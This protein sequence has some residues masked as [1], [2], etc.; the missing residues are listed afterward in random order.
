[1]F[2]FEKKMQFHKL[3]RLRQ[4]KGGEEKNGIRPQRQTAPCLAVAAPPHRQSCGDQHVGCFSYRRRPASFL[5][6]PDAG[7]TVPKR[8]NRETSNG[9]RAKPFP[10]RQAN[11]QMKM[12]KKKKRHKNGRD[13]RFF[14][15]WLEEGEQAQRRVS[16]GRQSC[17]RSTP[18]RDR[19]RQRHRRH[20]RSGAWTARHGP[21]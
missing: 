17:W 18:W 20:R 9:A 11:V 8:K 2:F 21:H 13:L 7:S 4:P 16:D 12:G 15:G 6:S 3:C 1:M 19:W 14:W 10:P 5:A